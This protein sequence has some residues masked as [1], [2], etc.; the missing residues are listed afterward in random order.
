MTRNIADSGCA[1]GLIFEW[2]DEWFRADWQAGPL[3]LPPA[4]RALW[5]NRLDPSQGFGL[6][7][8]D[9]GPA[10]VL[11]SKFSAWDSVPPLYQKDTGPAIQMNDGWDAERTLRSLAASSDAAFLYLRLQVGEIHKKSDGAPDLR[12]ADYYIG[13]NTDPG[14]LGGK[15]LPGPF[16]QVRSNS[17]ANFLL[18]L[19]GS[20]PAH[21]WIASNYDP[22]EARPVSDTS[23]TRIV[24]RIPFEPVL[25]DWSGFKDILVEANA[26]RFARDGH[27]FPPETVNQSVLHYGPSEQLDGSEAA[28]TADFATHAFIVRIPWALLLV[29][30]PSSH[31]VLARTGGGRSFEIRAT[32]GIE[33]FAISHL[34][35]RPIQ[36]QQFP[37]QGVPATDSLPG[38][39]EGV[40]ADLKMYHWAGWNTLSAIGRPKKGYAT[41]Q[42]AFRELKVPLS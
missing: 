38:L 42:K 3:A 26:R 24:Y 39:K 12:G 31:Q 32:P 22:R 7:T 2:Q 25:G 20:G 33:L 21:L 30:D 10:A 27:M 41:V 11:F 19:G 15:I 28:W 13:L 6:W 9:P 1:G 23:L 34:A 16:P 29:T 35:D 14:R 40:L 36:P 5:N 8:Y 17:G 4:R 18:H 37:R